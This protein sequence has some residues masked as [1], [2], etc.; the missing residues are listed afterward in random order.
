MSVK[1]KQSALDSV[2]VI[3]EAKQIKRSEMN[4]IVHGDIKNIIVFKGKDPIEEYSEKGVKVNGV[5]EIWLK[6][7]INNTIPKPYK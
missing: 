3:V 2:L 7:N 1:S 6:K 4:N 5:I